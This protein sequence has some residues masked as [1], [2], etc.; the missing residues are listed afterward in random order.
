MYHFLDRDGKGETRDKEAERLGAKN[1]SAQSDKRVGNPV[2]MFVFRLGVPKN[3]RNSQATGSCHPLRGTLCVP[4]VLSLGGL[5][6]ITR[7]RLAFERTASCKWRLFPS[8]SMPL[9][10]PR[11]LDS[12]SDFPL[13]LT[14]SLTLTTRQTT[15]NATE[16]SPSPDASSATLR[17]STPTTRQ[18]SESTVTQPQPTAAQPQPSQANN[19]WDSAWSAINQVGS[20]SWPPHVRGNLNMTRT[21][22]PTWP[23]RSL[24]SLCPEG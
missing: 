12:P 20:F 2:P 14:A 5:K 16:P 15:M 9:G 6:L 8:I 11:S 1:S 17:R 10:N 18:N 13:P 21:D 24:V 19:I 23:V 3:R 22:T 7:K 4:I